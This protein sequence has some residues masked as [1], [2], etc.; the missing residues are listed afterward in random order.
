MQSV[1]PKPP[2]P[3]RPRAPVGV[4]YYISNIIFH[5]K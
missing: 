1:E 2:P 3:P 4:R 5:E